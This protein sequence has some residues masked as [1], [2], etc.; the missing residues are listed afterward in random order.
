MPAISGLRS[1]YAIVNRLIYV[2]RMFDKIRLHHRGE[3]PVDFHAA[4][5]KGLDLRAS[6]FLNVDYDFVR[7][8]VLAGGTDEA[9][10]ADLFARGGTRSDHDCTVW[11]R[12]MQKL[13]WRDDRSEFL[14]DRVAAAGLE[15][16]GIE[17]FI[18]LI[19]YDEERSLDGHAR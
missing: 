11:S 4:L 18:D 9:I 5:G 15:G 19:E 7:Q 12:F 2:G 16:K 14:Q 3:L 8:R 13:G 17:T 1:P 10:L 6:N